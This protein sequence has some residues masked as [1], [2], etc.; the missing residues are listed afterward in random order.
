MAH[1]K[2]TSAP[3]RLTREQRASV[4][5]KACGKI[6]KLYFDPDFRGVDW[7]RLVAENREAVISEAEPER[8]ETAVHDVVR[9]L[10]TSHTGSFT[11]P[12]AGFRRGWRSEPPACAIHLIPTIGSSETSIKADRRQ[13]QGFARVTSCSASTAPVALLRRSQCSRWA[14]PH[15]SLSAEMELRSN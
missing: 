7:L 10:G 14:L 15:R 12:C 4:Y 8:F 2:S 3:P 6:S 13:R 11:S 5:D 9:Q 1:D